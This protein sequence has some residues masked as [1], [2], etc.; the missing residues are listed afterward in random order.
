MTDR[1]LQRQREI[2]MTSVTNAEIE[3]VAARAAVT[4]LV[5]ENEIRRVLQALGA[6]GFSVCL[7]LESAL[8]LGT[9]GIADAVRDTIACEDGVV[10]E[11]L[12]GTEADKNR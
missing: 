11:V 10:F 6:K 12:K 4:V 9:L 2:D 7:G 8:K 5:N 3:I 1:R